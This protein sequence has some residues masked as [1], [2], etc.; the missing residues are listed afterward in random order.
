MQPNVLH[1]VRHMR[2]F[3]PKIDKMIPG[4]IAHI[5]KFCIDENNYLDIPLCGE[6]LREQIQ[7]HL[8]PVCRVLG[9][10]ITEKTIEFLILP[11]P[12]DV[13]RTVPRNSKWIHTRLRGDQMMKEYLEGILK[14]HEVTDE[15]LL[16]TQGSIHDVLVK[17]IAIV[18]QCFTIQYNAFKERTCRLTQRKYTM[19]E[20]P[21]GKLKDVISMQAALSSVQGKG[22][23]PSAN[24]CSAYAD[25]IKQDSSVIDNAFL[26]KY[27]KNLKNDVKT[28]SNTFLLTL[29]AVVTDKQLQRRSSI[30]W[31]LVLKAKPG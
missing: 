23:S 9:Y 28:Q 5:I 15:S 17:K 3:K 13:I 24:P 29:S 7:K 16:C 14:I 26:L 19:H 4:K 1:R 21:Q 30:E 18:L 20:V 12:E 8:L 31:L 27:Y 11:H 2:K 10:L 22:L 25:I 6:I